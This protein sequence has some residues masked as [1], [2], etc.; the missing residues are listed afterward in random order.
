MPFRYVCPSELGVMARLAAV[1]L[2]ER[3]S[4][5]LDRWRPEREG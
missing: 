1:T 4:D 2:R 5:A 3:W